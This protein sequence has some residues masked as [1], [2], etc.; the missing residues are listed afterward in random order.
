MHY[1]QKKINIKW[2]A[3]GVAD[4]KTESLGRRASAFTSKVLIL[5]TQTMH[6][7][8]LLHIWP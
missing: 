4:N 1:L 3:S 6:E 2:G 8:F 5:G 7:N